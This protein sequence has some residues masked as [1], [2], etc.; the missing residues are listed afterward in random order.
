MKPSSAIINGCG[1][2]RFYS[3]IP[4]VI[5]FGSI[6]GNLLGEDV[7]NSSGRC[8]QNGTCHGVKI[9]ELA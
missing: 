6:F 2:N 9:Y 4:L 1:M 5:V 7:S 3:I 8:V